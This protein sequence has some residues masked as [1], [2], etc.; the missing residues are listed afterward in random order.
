MKKKHVFSDHFAVS[1]GDVRKTHQFC[2]ICEI[3]FEKYENYNEFSKNHHTNLKM[4]IK[5]VLYY[6]TKLFYEKTK[7]YIR[8]KNFNAHLSTVIFL[9]FV[10][11]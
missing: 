9:L 7:G 3:C 10:K 11:N 1:I 8:I 6:S 5:D 4:R 2:D